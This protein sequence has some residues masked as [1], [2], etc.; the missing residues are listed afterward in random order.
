M[1]SL[2]RLS[3]LATSLARAGYPRQILQVYSLWRRR[4]DHGKG[5]GFARAPARVGVDFRLHCIGAWG[6]GAQ[7]MSNCP[8][9]D[10]CQ[11]YEGMEA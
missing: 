10:D 5:P 7:R 9:S 8:G 6:E 11:A 3:G 1:R 2:L 4:W